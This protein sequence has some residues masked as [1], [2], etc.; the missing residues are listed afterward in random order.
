M[1]ELIK[2]RSSMKSNPSSV[3]SQKEDEVE[4]MSEV[5]AEPVQKAFL[6]EPDEIPERLPS[7]P[8]EEAKPDT[9]PLPRIP[10][11][12]LPYQDTIWF[13]KFFGSVPIPVNFSI[14]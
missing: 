1:K 8:I 12:I 2:Q 9:I 7:P 11:F 14:I 5:P 3:G 10:T 4:R 6:T 13:S